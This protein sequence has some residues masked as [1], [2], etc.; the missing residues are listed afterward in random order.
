MW[1]SLGGQ[2]GFLL[3]TEDAPILDL[4][5]DNTGSCE[6]LWVATTATHLNKWPINPNKANGFYDEEVELSEEEDLGVTDIDEPTPYFS[7]PITTLP[8]KL[9]LSCVCR[10]VYPCSI[11]VSYD[12]EEVCNCVVCRWEEHQGI[13]YSQ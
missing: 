11:Q 1:F 13:S 5:L 3:F 6:S 2:E 8:G 7:K 12:G 9:A 10:C 4:T